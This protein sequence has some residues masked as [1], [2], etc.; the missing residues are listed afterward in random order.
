VFNSVTGKDKGAEII[1]AGRNSRSFPYL[2]SR[3]NTPDKG[4]GL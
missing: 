2:D 1:S 4:Y 3:Y